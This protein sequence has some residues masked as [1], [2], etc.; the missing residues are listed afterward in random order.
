MKVA[1]FLRIFPEYQ[2]SFS[3]LAYADYLERRNL[4]FLI[5]F[6]FENAEALAWGELERQNFEPWIGHA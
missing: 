3:Q 4:R 1:D 5:D 2:V 6:G